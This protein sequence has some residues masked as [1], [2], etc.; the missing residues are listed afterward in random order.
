M[1]KNQNNLNNYYEILGIKRSA[2]DREVRSAF[3]KLALLYHPDKNQGNKLAEEKFKLINEAYQILTDGDKRF[4]FNQKLDNQTYINMPK[5]DKTKETN[6]DWQYKSYNEIQNMPDFSS[7]D[8]SGQGKFFEP[9][10]IPKKESNSLYYIIGFTLCI[11]IGALATLF[12]T[13]MNHLAA[14]EHYEKAVLY[15]NSENYFSAFRACNEALKYDEDYPEVLEMRGDIRFKQ[16]KYKMALLD[17]QLA[18]KNFKS[19]KVTLKQ[20]I[21]TTQAFAKQENINLAF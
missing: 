17:Y 7:G 9:K 12:G 20:K 8:Y 6:S 3:K 18:D 21:T 1:H 19:Q 15:Y 5:Q 4:Q 11:I 13:Y 16:E 10:E 2:T 14:E